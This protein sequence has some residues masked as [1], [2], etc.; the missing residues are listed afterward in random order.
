MA[1]KIKRN[2][3]RIHNISG[4]FL[5]LLI[6]FW[7]ISGIVMIFQGFPHAPKED[8]F[9]HLSTFSPGQFT[10]LQAPPEDFRGRVCL[11]LCGDRPVYRLYT[12][13][14]L[15]RIIDACSLD[16]L[17]LFTEKYAR[18]LC[19]SFNGEPVTE[20]QLLEETDQWIPWSY[21]IPL[22]PFYK[23]SMDDRDR[24]VLYVSAVSGEIIQE[25]N[26]KKRWAARFGAIPH[27]IY[28]K[29]LR[30]KI[31]A[32]RNVVIILALLG[33]VVSISGLYMGIV[34]LAKKKGK[35]SPFR[36]LWYR[37]HH[38]AGFFFGIFLFTFLLSGF[39]SMVDV[40]DWMA[41][42]KKKEKVLIEWNQELELKGHARL[43]PAML[44]SALEQ[45]EGIRRIEW[46]TVGG[47]PSYWVY[48][49]QYQVPAIYARDRDQI[50]KASPLSMEDV[51][52]CTGQLFGE[53]PVTITL[54]EGY[55]RYYV[56]SATRYRPLPVYKLCFEDAAATCLYIN[57][58]T[59]EEVRRTTRNSR[60]RRWLY[61]ALHTFDFPALKKVD[62]LRKA[63]LIF[64]SLGGLAISITGL[65]LSIR[66]FR[67]KTRKI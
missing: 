55:D 30:L 61:R 63:L 5:S 13:R 60:I 14:K 9:L 31:D 15:Q 37:W 17:P 2:I 4:S 27:W 43:T 47:K 20:I 42:V 45:K 7:F 49:D 58:D 39:F 3:I 50:H 25:T 48:Y 12:D 10:G 53:I 67:R 23:C 40:P 35:L 18:E 66:W 62:P 54:L 19:S 65:A 32:W 38:L 41:G 46:K 16:P 8:S 52:E 33:L 36:K 44:S 1:G 26:S 11:E 64:L 57:P 29:N 56:G 6:M 22:L 24:T 21:Y 28:F 34:F 59:G 51:K